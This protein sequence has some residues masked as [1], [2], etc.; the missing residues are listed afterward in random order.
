M[1][2]LTAKNRPMAG[3]L[4]LFERCQACNHCRV[5]HPEMYPKG[6]LKFS[7]DY[8]T[9]L[10]CDCSEFIPFPRSGKVSSRTHMAGYRVL[11][12]G[13]TV[14]PGDYLQCGKSYWIVDGSN[15]VGEEIEHIGPY[16]TVWTDR[17]IK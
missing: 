3:T 12:V 11:Q 6:A 9:G 8:R 2:P 15:W 16:S 7:V 10:H 4:Q 5:D 13:E 17:P 1:I 14:L